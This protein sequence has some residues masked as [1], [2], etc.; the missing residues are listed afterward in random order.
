MFKYNTEMEIKKYIE[1]LLIVNG[2]NIDDI[3]SL[4]NRSVYVKDFK[5]PDGD[6]FV[7]LTGFSFTTHKGTIIELYYDFKTETV[8]SAYSCDSGHSVLF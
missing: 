8:I 1:L 4:L 3:L 7:V 2:T 5:S 6:S